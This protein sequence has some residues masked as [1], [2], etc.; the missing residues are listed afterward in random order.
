MKVLGL[1]ASTTAGSIALVDGDDLRGEVWVSTSRTHSE[2]ILHG[3]DQVMRETQMTCGELD[4]V[5]VGLGPGSF[6]GLRIALSTAKGLALARGIPVAG[7]PTLEALARNTPYWGECICPA[8]DARNGLV[9]GGVY[10]VAGDGRL[11]TQQEAGL[12]EMR[13]WAM[14]ITGPVLFLGS[15]AAAYRE[16]IVSVLGGLAHFP[17]P[18]L[19]HPRAA[20]TA[21]LG[22]DVL[23][24]RGGDHLDSLI[25]LYLRKSEAE[26]LHGMGGRAGQAG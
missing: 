23:L 21:R 18:E 3:I 6:T 9:Y 8:V 10:R 13:Q 1:E 4:G 22:R 7:I 14:T 16:A 26:R 2:R 12:R 25:P 20:V 11:T 5:A 24:S 15:G 17:P 19:M